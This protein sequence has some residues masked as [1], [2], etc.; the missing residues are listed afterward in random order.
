MKSTVYETNL[1]SLPLLGRGK[2]RDIY[3]V[4]SDHLLIVA[5]DRLSAFDV[6]FPEPIPEK[7]KILNDLS[8]FWFEKMKILIQNHLTNLRVSDVLSDSS[9]CDLVGGR[10]VVV[11]RLTPLPIEAVVRGYIIGSGWEDY[12]K[13]GRTSGIELESGLSLAEKLTSPIFTPSTKA[14][15]GSHDEN[16]DFNE[17]CNLVGAK[18]ADQIRS[19]SIEIYSRAAE[20]ALNK[21]IIIADTKMEFGLSSEGELVLID[22]LLTPDSSRFWPLDSYTIGNSPKSFDK[23]FVRDYLESIKWDKSPPAPKLPR[24][25]IEKTFA[26]YKAAH[27]LLTS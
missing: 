14:E 2:V 1:R 24:S 26:R 25:V 16:I 5:T 7:G 20:Y 27:D 10:G 6:V 11:K 15:L 4:D 17:A 12:R 9:E 8:S 22:E 13:T 18:I 21:G 23:Q 19:T 3:A